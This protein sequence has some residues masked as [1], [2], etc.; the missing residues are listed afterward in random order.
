MTRFRRSV[1]VALFSAAAL[2]YEVLLVRAFAI[3]QFHHFAYMAISV[4]MLGFG[5]SG[6]VLALAGRLHAATAE[7]LFAW[8]GVVA[9]FSFVASPA[10]VDLISL[11]ATQLAWDLRQWPRLAAVYLLLAVP[12]GATALAILVALTLEHRHPGTVYG[13]SFVG[14]GFGAAFAV[15]ILWFVFPDRALAIP[16]L[17]AA[18]GGLVCVGRRGT[19]SLVRTAAWAGAALSATVVVLPLWTLDVSQYKGLPQVEAFPDARRVAEHTS[20]LGWV[21][22]VEAPAQ[23]YA[24]GLSLAYQGEFPRQTG[25]FVDG[26]LVG[27]FPSAG[28]DAGAGAG[29]AAFLDWLPTALPYA[30]KE[31]RRVLILGAGGGT[32]VA[33]A[34]T[35]GARSVVAVELNP[36]VARL[37]QNADGK[38]GGASVEWVVGDARS[39]VVRTNERFDLITLGAVGGFGTSAAGVHSL[40]ADFLH[41][42]DAYVDYLDRLAPGGVLAITRWLTIPP[43]ENVRTILTVTHALRQVAPQTVQEGL[44]VSRSW[45]TVTVMA[46][47]SGFAADEIDALK[48]WT[49]QRGFDIDWYRGLEQPTNEFHLLEEPV[50]FDAA[51]AGIAGVGAAANFASSYPFNVSPVDDARPYPHHFIRPGSV[52]AFL[53][54]SRGTWLPFAEWGYV[55]LIATLVQSV[56]LAA[57]L[58]LLPVAVSTRGAQSAFSFPLA[59]YFG[60]IGLAYLSAEIAA[61]QQLSLLLGHP[62]YAV[63]AVLAVFLVCSGLGSAWSDRIEVRRGWLVL[64]AVA[65]LLLMH[66]GILLKLVH[67]LQPFPLP[68]RAFVGLVA[69]APV[70]FLMGLPFPMGLRLL[71]RGDTIRT[72]WAWATNGFASVV[73][74]PLAVLVALELGS[75]I[76]FLAAAISY[77]VA[78]WIQRGAA[79]PQAHT[80]PV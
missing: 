31:R 63:A 22:A 15:A 70:A 43:R 18:G 33:N 24:P 80:A 64:G 2:T 30:L 36:D 6:T 55:A 69:V 25:L 28:P 52:G 48:R 71:A 1:A 44:F 45:G 8:S 74:A 5:A 29:A 20:P 50:L 34:V 54:S 66:A 39:F 59:G 41:T 26:A 77:A 47:P 14:S 23:R 79:K 35:H 73:A 49:T 42:V 40:G 78:A 67:L 16:A 53:Q 7:R 3:E 12:F 17:L 75:P 56:V 10:L 60:A 4:A 51:A 61:I 46:K 68:V 13:A 62:V 38:T 65:F 9:A 19:S 11:D 32:E 72:A 76:V 21:V 37:A 58:T 57:M 27:A